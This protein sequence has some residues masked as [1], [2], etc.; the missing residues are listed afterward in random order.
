MK[1]QDTEKNT[2]H[3]KLRKESEESESKGKLRF[4]FSSLIE[5]QWETEENSGKLNA[6]YA[7]EFF[8]W[9]MS[10]RVSSRW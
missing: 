9:Y 7:H 1:E 6:F 2:L 5:E 8:T 4:T 10:N 3:D